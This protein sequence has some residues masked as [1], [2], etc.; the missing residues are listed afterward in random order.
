MTTLQPGL[1][2][3]LM[4]PDVL[5][6]LVKDR[7]LSQRAR[8]EAAD[9]L[10]LYPSR[11]EIA[12]I[13]GSEEATLLRWLNVMLRCHR[14]FEILAAFYQGSEQSQFAI[15]S[16][17]RLYPDPAGIRQLCSERVDFCHM[18]P[19]IA[20]LGSTRHAG[21]R[22][23]GSGA[24]ANT[25]DRPDLRAGAAAHQFLSELAGEPHCRRVDRVWRA[26]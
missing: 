18:T 4:A 2:G 10:A 19:L 25:G 8:Q 26:R 22:P 3:I 1:S 14:M 9:L 15:R 12:A 6:L 11:A 13:L 7:L 16:A 24:H 20:D 21:T 5:R 17:L 23:L